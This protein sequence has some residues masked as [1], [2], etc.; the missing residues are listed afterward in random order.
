[1][2]GDAISL[3]DYLTVH[4]PTPSFNLT[5][6]AAEALVGRPEPTDDQIDSLKWRIELDVALR[7][8]WADAA[9]RDTSAPFKWTAWSGGPGTLPVGTRADVRCRNGVVLF[10]CLSES[11]YWPHENLGSDIVAYRLSGEAK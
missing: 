1:M 8:L 10:N 5:A 7:S 2:N 9:M 3:R 4:A 11:L 6:A